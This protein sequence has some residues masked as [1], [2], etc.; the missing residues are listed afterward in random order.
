MAKKVEKLTTRQIAARK[1]AQTRADNKR[2]ADYRAR[3]LKAAETRKAN[4]RLS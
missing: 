3:G 1:A 2:K 4:Q